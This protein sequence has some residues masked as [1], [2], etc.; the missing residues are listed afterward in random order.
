MSLNWLAFH[1][2]PR[3][4]LN[5]PISG[6][7]TLVAYALLL[8]YGLFHQR[9]SFRLHGRQWLLFAACV[10]AAPLLSQGLVVRFDMLPNLA[11]VTWAPFVAIPML[12]AAL[13]LGS[14]PAA[15]VGLV[16]GLTRALYTSG[17]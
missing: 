3:L 10:L 9:A 13:W 14:G 4:E 11:V 7:L 15:V 5:L 1:S 6:Y 12:A 17:R 2:S 8:A 16:T